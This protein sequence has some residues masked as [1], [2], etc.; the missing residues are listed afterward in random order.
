MND[1]HSHGEG[2]GATIEVLY[3]GPLADELAAGLPSEEAVSFRTASR[4]EDGIDAIGPEI[5]CVVAGHDPPAVDARRFLDQLRADDREQ[6]FILYGPRVRAG[7]VEEILASGG[8]YL[9][10]DSDTTA[11]SVLGVR[12]RTTVESERT[13]TDLERKSR[14]MNQAPVGITIGDATVDDEPLVYVNDQFERL[15]GYDRSAVLGRNCRFLQGAGTD[16]ET[17]DRLRAA[18]ENQE[19]VSVELLNYRADGTPFWN[20]LDIAP[21]RDDGE[22]THYFGFQKDVT[23]R[24]SL[25]EALQQQTELQDRFASV[26]SHDLRNP[27]TIAEGHLE[28]ARENRDDEDLSAVADALDRMD[29]IID[30]VLKIARQGVA[31]EDP[32]RLDLA[33][34][35]REAGASVGIQP[36]IDEELPSVEGDPERVRTLFENLLRNSKDHAGET[37]TV[38]VGLY[39]GGFYVEDDG[40]G[41]PQDDRESVFEWGVTTADDGTGYG[42]AVVRTIAR[43]HGWEVSVTDGRTGGARFEIAVDA[44]PSVGS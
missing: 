11:R 7:V 31:I 27:L 15:T 4:S 30:G 1:S 16:E 24:K 26:V 23:E 5:D 39:D 22:V 25:E 44:R 33:A 10:S 28:I 9:C 37:P 43:A 6:P 13:R 14:A 18:I 42:L 3:V 12:I 8:D 20:Q 32:E 2:D 21:V 40:L 34:I 38:R 19:P 36:E 29:G 41:I 35:A 17:V